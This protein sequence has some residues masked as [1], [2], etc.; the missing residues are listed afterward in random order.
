MNEL[1]YQCAY[2]QPVQTRGSGKSHHQYQHTYRGSRGSPESKH[3]MPGF[4][5]LPLRITHH[6]KNTTIPNQPRTTVRQHGERTFNGINKKEQTYSSFPS[7]YER[8]CGFASLYNGRRTFFLSKASPVFR[9]S[10]L[11]ISRLGSLLFWNMARKRF[12]DNLGAPGVE[13]ENKNSKTRRACVGQ[14]NRW[15]VLV[16]STLSSTDLNYTSGLRPYDAACMLTHP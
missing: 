4:N 8:T 12:A 7:P 2:P 15:Q 13:W 16:Q 3:F 5:L 11:V 10:R 14:P 6:R 1:L 9:S